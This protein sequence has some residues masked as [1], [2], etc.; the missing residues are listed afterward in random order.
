[1]EQLL[2]EDDEEGVVESE[3]EEESPASPVDSGPDDPVGHGADDEERLQNYSDL[4]D[5][6][7]TRLLM[8]LGVT[9]VTPEF[10]KIAGTGSSMTDVANNLF[11]F[12]W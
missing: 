2:F 10:S 1:M 5:D 3:A 6:S 4:F 8:K 11:T 7:A 9:D 12:L